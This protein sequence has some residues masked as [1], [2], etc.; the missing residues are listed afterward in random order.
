MTIW[1]TASSAAHSQ[2]PVPAVGPVI[3]AGSA[4]GSSRSPDAAGTP[5]PPLAAMR[6]VG[7]ISGS[8]EPGPEDALV[9]N[10]GLGRPRYEHGTAGLPGRS[11]PGRGKRPTFLLLFPGSGQ[12]FD[13]VPGAVTRMA[14]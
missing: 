4:A 7:V 10:P 13:G 6:G 3:R 9:R 2:A 11:D 5:P 1:V 8:G 12:L 14:V